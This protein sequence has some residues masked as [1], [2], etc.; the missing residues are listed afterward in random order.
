MLC[1]F[2]VRMLKYSLKFFIYFFAHKKLKKPTQKVAYLWQL[3]VVFFSTA[4]TAQ[5]SSELHF[6]F[7]NSFI[8]PSLVGSLGKW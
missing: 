6:R 8:Q 3:G 1:N 7:L 5:N 4:P 2:S